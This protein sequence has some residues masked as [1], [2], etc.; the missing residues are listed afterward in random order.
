MQGI[1]PHVRAQLSTTYGNMRTTF[2][3]HR[4]CVPPHMP[5]YVSQL[6]SSRGLDNRRCCTGSHSADVCNLAPLHARE[7]GHGREKQNRPD[8]V[9]GTLCTE[10]RV[11]S[12][13]DRERQPRHGINLQNH[14]ICDQSSTESWPHTVRGEARH[15]LHRAA[16]HIQHFYLRGYRVYRCF[17]AVPRAGPHFSRSQTQSRRSMSGSVVWILRPVRSVLECNQPDGFM[18]YCHLSGERTDQPSCHALATLLAGLQRAPVR[19]TMLQNT[20]GH[21]LQSRSSTQP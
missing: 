1:R 13:R 7:S 14:T 3:G 5:D 20:R 16:Q 15:G 17:M 12:S 8:G 21:T 19:I 2:T 9:G 4:P 6:S 18:I 10:K 11:Q